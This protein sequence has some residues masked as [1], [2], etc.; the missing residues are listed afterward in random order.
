M[1]RQV[2]HKILPATVWALIVSEATLVFTAYVA[3]AYVLIQIDP[4]L[5]LIWEDG[6]LRILT[7]V[8]WILI[9]LYFQ[10]LY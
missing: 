2:I 9:G 10:D 3:V 5:W 6:L 4:L 1:G 7:L 8:A